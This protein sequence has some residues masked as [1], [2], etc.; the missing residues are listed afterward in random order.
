MPSFDGFYF[1]FGEHA[2]RALVTPILYLEVI[3]VLVNGALLWLL[4]RRS[5][6]D[7]QADKLEKAA[8]AIRRAKL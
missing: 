1:L 5:P 8:R 7:I 4:F 6:A 2:Q 3:L